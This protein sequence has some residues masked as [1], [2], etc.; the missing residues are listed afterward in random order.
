MLL[1][2]C[3]LVVVQTMQLVVLPPGSERA[4]IAAR[5]VAIATFVIFATTVRFFAR[6]IILIHVIYSMYIY[7]SSNFS[8]FDLHCCLYIMYVRLLVDLSRSR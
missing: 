4:R 2:F 7:V 3:R 1:W 8:N 5:L 6:F